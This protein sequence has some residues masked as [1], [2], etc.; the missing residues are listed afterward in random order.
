MVTQEHR[1]QVDQIEADAADLMNTFKRGGRGDVVAPLQDLSHISK[2]ASP[3]EAVTMMINAR[4]W[5]Q[6]QLAR[7]QAIVNDPRMANT[8]EGKAALTKLYALQGAISHMPPMT[9]QTLSDGTKIMG[10]QEEAQKLAS[11]TNTSSPVG[12]YLGD[13]PGSLARIWNAGKD[14]ATEAAGGSP[15]AKEAPAKAD[16]PSF[17]DEKAVLDAWNAGKLKA[18][19][20][21]TFKDASGNTVRRHIKDKASGKY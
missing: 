9:T 15:A 4:G 10:L 7:N 5:M 14:Y 8:D 12:Q 3:Q 17:A 21:V 2:A 6:D 19:Q 13:L 20:W 16:E 11:A 18:G 1:K